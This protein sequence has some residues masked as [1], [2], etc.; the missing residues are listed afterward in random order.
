MLSNNNILLLT[1]NFKKLNVKNNY[2]SVLPISD[3]LKKKNKYQRN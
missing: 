3:E 1:Q 2:L